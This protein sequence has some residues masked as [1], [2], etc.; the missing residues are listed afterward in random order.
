MPVTEGIDLPTTQTTPT[1][2]TASNAGGGYSDG[3]YTPPTSSTPTTTIDRS[4]ADGGSGATG[5]T[6]G[7][8]PTTLAGGW[9]F[10]VA[11]TNSYRD[12]FG[13]PRSGGRVHNGIDI[14]AAQGTPILSPVAGQVSRVWHNTGIGGYAIQVKG[15]DGLTY[16]FAHMVAGPRDGNGAEIKAGDSVGQGQMIGQVGGTGNANGTMHLHFGIRDQNMQAIN[17]MPFL[18]AG[19]D[20]YAHVQQNS[21]GTWT[22]TAFTSAGA[23]MTAGTASDPGIWLPTEGTFYTVDGQR[24]VTY[25]IS[26][27]GIDSPSATIFFEI[28]S[29]V[30]APGGKS[31]SRNA[32]EQ[33]AAAWENGGSA[34]AFRDVIPNSS[35]SDLIENTLF[36]MGIWG[37][38]A[39]SDAGVLRVIA[40]AIARPD[41]EPDEFESRL[42]QTDWGQSHTDRQKT[43]N[44]K[45][46]AQQDQEIVDNATTLIGTWFT[47]TGEELDWMSFDSDG[48][49][50]VSVDELKAGNPALYEASL[51]WSSGTKTERQLLE[52]W[53]KPSARAVDNS[54]WNRI[55]LQ[56][57]QS[58][59]AAEVGKEKQAG[60]VM[61]LYQSYGIPI[62]W[63][64]ALKIGDEVFMNRTSLEEVEESLDQQAM[65]LYPGKPAGVTTMTY[66]SPYI[67]QYKSILEVPTVGLDDT[68]LQAAMANGTTLGDFGNELRRDPRWMDTSNA[69]TSHYQT[70]GAL[71]EQMGF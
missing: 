4:G 63:D 5:R 39:M 13:A 49:G 59:G 26:D 2:N 68:A 58:Q 19:S 6:I 65:A 41:M 32:W 36:R 44:D 45:S 20:A 24:F 43:W 47:Y 9:V 56:E 50:V 46:K 54:P 57:E 17:A 60:Q 12:T 11:G 42:N 55:L 52:S 61:N 33:K 16:Y 64:E 62:T 29:G 10:P 23:G 15:T 18:D 27:G 40:A 51:S 21:D 69:R 48:D 34:E 22:N 28:P 35:W 70:L 31:L 37:T 38:S 1:T 66:A 67:E 8:T 3:S 53:I 7:I 30:P 25:D 14:M 71:G